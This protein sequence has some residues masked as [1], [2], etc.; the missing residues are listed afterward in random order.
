MFPI[1]SGGQKC[2]AAG[3]SYQCNKALLF[4]LNIIDMVGKGKNSKTLVIADETKQECNC[5]SGII[6][7]F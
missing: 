3:Q 4:M 2:S 5:V 6:I 1:F 7:S